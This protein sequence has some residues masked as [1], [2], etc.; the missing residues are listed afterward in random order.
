MEITLRSKFWYEITYADGARLI[1]QFLDST[2]DGRIR[3]KLCNGEER[4]NIFSGQFMKI[5]ELGEAN[6]C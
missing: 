4:L 1:F 3:C 2:E 6:P 5:V